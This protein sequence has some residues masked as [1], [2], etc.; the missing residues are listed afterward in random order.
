MPFGTGAERSGSS[1]NKSNV[2]SPPPIQRHMTLGTCN[3]LIHT[4]NLCQQ[5]AFTPVLLF[6]VM[7]YPSYSW[8][9]LS[10]MDFG[11]SC[12]Q[13]VT[14]DDTKSVCVTIYLNQTL[15]H[16]LNETGKKHEYRYFI[17][18]SAINRVPALQE[19]WCTD[20]FKHIISQ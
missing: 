20:E 11:W 18:S 17:N 1:H 8:S 12:N 10:N 6:P 13:L 2:T 7:R 19:L 4:E 5:Y 15:H 14:T 9:S 3:C 16:V